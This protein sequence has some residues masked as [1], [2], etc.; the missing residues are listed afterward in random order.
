VEV[1]KRIE[2]STEHEEGF[3]I[4]IITPLILIAV[5]VHALLRKHCMLKLCVIMVSFL[6]CPRITLAAISTT[7]IYVWRSYVCS[8][9][10]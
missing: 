5:F 4:I 6:L 7:L 1:L 2:L 8:E 9:D 10:E 3:D